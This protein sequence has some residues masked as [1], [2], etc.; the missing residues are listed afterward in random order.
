MR[1][2]IADFDAGQKSGCGKSPGDLLPSSDNFRVAENPG[3]GLLMTTGPFIGTD[4]GKR[5]HRGCSSFASVSVWLAA[6]VGQSSY[7]QI[8]NDA[9]VPDPVLTALL[10]D[11]AAYNTRH[12]GFSTASLTM[13]RCVRRSWALRRGRGCR[14]VVDLG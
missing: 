13:R 9:P 1:H 11:N 6:S 12:M 7:F 8:R 5:G 14:L 10:I 4:A 2:S 3:V